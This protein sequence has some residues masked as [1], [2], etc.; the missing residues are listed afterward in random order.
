MT[1]AQYLDRYH[2][3]SEA[4]RRELNTLLGRLQEGDVEE[5]KRTLERWDVRVDELWA[6]VETPA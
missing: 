3:E 5:A 2:E 4:M 6:Q 1:H